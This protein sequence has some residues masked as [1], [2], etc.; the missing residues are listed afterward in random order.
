MRNKIPFIYG[1]LNKEVYS[2]FDINE[3]K[4][5]TQ[6]Q[7]GGLSASNIEV[8]EL[9]HAEKNARIF[10]LPDFNSGRLNFLQRFRL[11]QNLPEETV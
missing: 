3:L 9:L 8:E 11:R 10:V 2:E 5:Q 7:N 1:S 6:I 4:Q